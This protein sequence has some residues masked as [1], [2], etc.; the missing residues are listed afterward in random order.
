MN[1]PALGSG[2]GVEGLS[3]KPQNLAYP[4]NQ[5]LR[6]SFNQYNQENSREGISWKIRLSIYH[7]W[8]IQYVNNS[9]LQS[10]SSQ[11][12]RMGLLCLSPLLELDKYLSIK[13]FSSW[14]TNILPILSFCKDK[15]KRLGF[16]NV[17]TIDITHK[18]SCNHTQ[19]NIKYRICHSLCISLLNIAPNPNVSLMVS[20][21]F[22]FFTVCIGW[23][24]C[25]QEQKEYEIPGE[26]REVKTPNSFHVPHSFFK[27]VLMRSVTD[28]SIGDITCRETCLVAKL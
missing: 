9:Y 20:A 25:P 15:E 24:F 16:C 8:E 5:R 21:K 10:D 19:Q 7:L 23:Y 6:P 12:C 22:P 1:Y 11:Y 2:G 18:R 17:R 26:K 28:R 3:Q 14:E 13:V 4:L 27:Q